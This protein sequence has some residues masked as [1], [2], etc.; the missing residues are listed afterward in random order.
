M[1]PMYPLLLRSA[2]L[3]D[4][5]RERSCGALM[6]GFIEGLRLGVVFCDGRRGYRRSISQLQRPPVSHAALQ[7]GPVRATECPRIKRKKKWIASGGRALAFACDLRLCNQE[8]NAKPLAL[9]PEIILAIVPLLLFD[10]GRQESVSKVC[11]IRSRREREGSAPPSGGRHEKREAEGVLLLVR[12]SILVL[13]KDKML[14]LNSW[15]FIVRHL[16]QTIDRLQENAN[17]VYEAE[18]SKVSHRALRSAT[19]MS[20]NF[21]RQRAVGQPRSLPQL[22][23]DEGVWQYLHSSFSWLMKAGG[24]RLQERLVEG[25][26]VNA[27]VANDEADGIATVLGEF[28][29]HRL[30]PG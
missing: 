11:F 29:G 14:L 9:F 3:T 7:R 24:L 23:G 5:P 26:P 27:F 17:K 28:K 10:Q 19:M 20:D 1:R 15:P 4:R 16:R 2:T 22:A 30:G 8:R 6:S 12:Y 21:R 13:M 18:E 25:P